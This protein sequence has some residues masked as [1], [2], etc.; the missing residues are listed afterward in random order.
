MAAFL[1]SDRIDA[2]LSAVESAVD[3]IS[4]ESPDQHLT[5]DWDAIYPDGF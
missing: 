5:L 2:F 4:T 3:R 1:A